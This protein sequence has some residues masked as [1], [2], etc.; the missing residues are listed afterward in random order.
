[1][2]SDNDAGGVKRAGDDDVADEEDDKDADDADDAEGV[3][4]IVDD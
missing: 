3:D 4:D 1:M 2:S